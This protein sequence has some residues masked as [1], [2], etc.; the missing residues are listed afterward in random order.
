MSLPASVRRPTDVDL[1]VRIGSVSL[2]NPIIAASGTFAYGVEFAHLVDLNS[3]GGIVVKGLSAQPMAGAPSPRMCETA[4][5]M[6]NAVG[7][8]NI[9]VHAFVAE[10]LPELRKYQTAIITNVFGQ[11]VAEYVEVIRV[12]E[13]AEGVAAYE[14]NISCPNTDRGGAEFGAEPGLAAEVVSA[15]RK[16][17]KRPLWVKLAP[18]SSIREIAKAAESA[19]A[20]AVTVANTYPAMSLDP[21]SGRSRLGR[22]YG[23]LSGPAIRPLTLK[24]VY[25]V[26][27]EVKIPVIGLGGVETC[28]D[29]LEYFAAGASAVQVGTAHF[30]NPRASEE[31][32]QGLRNLHTDLKS[33]TINTLDRI[34]HEKIA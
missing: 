21:L 33:L 11:T 16:A 18:N 4:G 19:G 2:K 25:D 23:G 27:R 9:G 10:K 12:L 26:C 29:A 28:L 34:E 13:Q 30:S 31:V 15:A 1:S 24:L 7:L 5:G 6:L 22:L 14:L 32:I 3:L 17:A 20:D 8:Q